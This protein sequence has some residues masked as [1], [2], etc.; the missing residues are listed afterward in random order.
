MIIILKSKSYARQIFSILNKYGENKK[1]ALDSST[2]KIFTF[3]KI[4]KFLIDFEI[5]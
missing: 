5:I 1:T 2:D 3:F 4:N